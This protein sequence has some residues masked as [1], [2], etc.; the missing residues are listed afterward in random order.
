MNDDAQEIARVYNEFGE[1][2][3]RSRNSASGRLANEYIDMPA[4]LSLIPED[5]GGWHVVDAGCGSGIYATELARRGARVVGIDISQKMIEIAERNRPPDLYI[6]YHI[7]DI[8]HM[9][10]PDGST[11]LVLCTYVLEN[12]EDIDAVFKEFHRIMK[13][14]SSCVI[15]LSHPLRAQAAREERAGQEIWI[16]QDY[17]SGG[18]R[19]SDFGGGMVVPKYKR[20]LEGYTEAIAR[21]ELLMR[22]VREPRPVPDG[23]IVDPVGYEKAVRLP[24]LLAM[25][26]TRIDES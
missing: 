18:M 1:Y 26:L 23:R 5:L 22:H 25:E 17:F 16:L 6:S 13:P 10:I 12:L 4:V 20:P 7:G 19:H 3:H 2:Y 14:R 11:D 8:A 15:S 24:Q 9:K 21:A